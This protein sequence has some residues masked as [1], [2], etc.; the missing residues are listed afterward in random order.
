MSLADFSMAEGLEGRR[1]ELSKGVVIVTDVPNPAH[2]KTTERTRRAFTTY[3]DRV[4]GVIEHVLASH[5]CK[6]L[7][8][9]TQSERHPDVSVY[10]TP[11][12]G[13]DSE[14]WSV[15]VP[16]I[17]V[18]VV[19]AESA[20]R[21]YEEKPEDYLLFG[22]LEYWIVDAILGKVTINRR[23]RGRWQPRELRAGETYSTHLLPGF[24]LD[25]GAILSVA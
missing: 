1:Y 18:E 13:E 23:V 7:I 11:P 5:E 25:V 21:D 3:Q 24:T 14:V 19:S 22:V 6:L 8:E 4:P 15:W 12:P 17:V 2:M 10:K 20:R 16:E 9:H